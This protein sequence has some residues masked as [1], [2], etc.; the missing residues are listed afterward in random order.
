[1]KK[2]SCITLAIMVL[3]ITLTSIAGCKK[4]ENPIKFPKGTFPDSVYNLTGLNTQYDDY[5]STLYL[6]GSTFPVIFSSNRGS[7]GGQFDLVQGT[8]SFQ[9]DQTNGV[10]GVSGIM[11]NDPFYGTIISKANTAG[12][13]FGPLSQFGSTDGYE[14]LMVA[15]QIGSGPLD[16]YYLKYLPKFN[17]SIPIVN[18]PLPVKLLNSAYDEAYITFDFNADSVYFTSNRNGNYD[19]FLHKRPGGTMLDTWLNQDFAASTPVDSV[20]SG[21][22]DKCPFFY[23]NVM[24]FTSNRPGGAGGYDLY[25]SVFKSGKWSSPVNC[26]PKINTGSDE[27]RPVMGYHQD[28]NNKFMVFS[29]NKPGGTGGFDLY[30]TGINIP[31]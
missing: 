24:L 11:A 22:D 4:T 23:K 15:S 9:F 1:M 18:G 3:V 13:D 20:N 19:I 8:I 27:Y 25:Y 16:L 2:S 10:F 26:G 31:K 17:N 29:S 6:I 30:L 28:Y 12:N 21:F 7:T 14:Y 5:N